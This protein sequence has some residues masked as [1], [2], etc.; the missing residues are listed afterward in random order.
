MFRILSIAVLAAILPL[1]GPAV[2]ALLAH[3]EPYTVAG[4]ADGMPSC[5]VPPTAGDALRC[6]G[7]GGASCPAP[8]M[9]ADR[10][11]GVIRAGDTA[12]AADTPGRYRAP[13][14]PGLFR[15]PIAT[16]T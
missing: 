6:A 12:P 15:P 16:R 7:T 1:G 9:P 14:L 2:H 11:A 3:G 10:I 5:C 13:T 8:A 4:E